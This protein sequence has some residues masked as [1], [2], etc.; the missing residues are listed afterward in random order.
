MVGSYRKEATMCFEFEYE[1]LRRRA[2]EA[3]EQARK[4]EERSRQPE[5]GA[6]AAPE[7]VKERDP[8]PA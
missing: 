7:P 1:V 2:E 6:P 4:A 8:V 5:P 3:R